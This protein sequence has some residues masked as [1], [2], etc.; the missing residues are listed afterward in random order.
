MKNLVLRYGFYATLVVVGIQLVFYFLI[1]FTAA[2]NFELGEILGYSTIFLSMIFVFLGMKK[3]RDEN[4]DGIISFWEAL[5]VGVLIVVI[6][7]IAFGLYNWFYVE[8]MDPQFVDNYFNYQL[9]KAEAAMSSADFQAM[10]TKMEAQKETFQNPLIGSFVM[11]MTVFV[12]GF[13]VALVSSIIL[14]KDKQVV[15]NNFDTV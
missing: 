7:S 1:D 8:V 13:I 15:E 9:E 5:K 3:Y 10:K 12:I 2:E 11:F 6:P 4:N 14:K